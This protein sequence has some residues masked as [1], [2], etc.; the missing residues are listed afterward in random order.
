MDRVYDVHQDTSDRKFFRTMF[1]FDSDGQR[2]LM[3]S[4]RGEV[5]LKPG[6]TITAIL[7]RVQS[8]VTKG[9]K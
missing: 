2:Y 8:R 1:S 9:F 7:R 3:L 6:Q 5:D 4:L